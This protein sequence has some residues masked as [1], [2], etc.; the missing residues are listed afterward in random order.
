MLAE[1]LDGLQRPTKELSSKF[2]YDHTGS[3]LFEDITRL[4]EYYPTRTEEAL[5]E[6]HVPAWVERLAP[7]TLVE[8]GAGSARKTRVLL[9]AMVSEGSGRLFVP[10]DL[11]GDFLRNTVL[12]VRREYPGLSVEPL[13]A[14]IGKP[15]TLGDELPAPVLFVLLGGTIGN[16]PGES[17]SKLLSG[18]RRAMGPEDRLVMGAD[19]RP[20]GRKSVEDIEAAYNDDAGVTAA[21]NLNVLRVLN[22]ELGAD[23]ALDQF[24]HRAIY[25]TGRGRIEMHLVS[26]ARQSIRFGDGSSVTFDDGESVRTEISCKYDQESMAV[27]LESAGLAVEEWTQDED[28][29]YSLIVARPVAAGD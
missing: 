21:F 22:R 26:Q 12:Q 25:D 19:L 6:A 29:R 4:P 14:D 16:F 1:V 28:D 8:L 23:F 15:L 5:L 13:V 7:A 11:S 2:F 24:R 3:E 20:G 18:V 17:G 10:V 9:D 27:L